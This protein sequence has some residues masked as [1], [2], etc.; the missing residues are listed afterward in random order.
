MEDLFER[1][2]RILDHADSYLEQARKTGE[3]AVEEYASVVKA[4]RLLLKYMRRIT[5]LSDR[6]TVDLNTSKLDLQDKIHFDEL[7]GIYNRRFLEEGLGK[8]AE[9]LARSRKPLGVLMVD[10]DYFKRYNDTYGHGMGDDC[11]HMVAEAL[12]E[13]VQRPGDFAARYG[14]EEFVVVMPGADEEETRGMARR[15]L[16]SVR[17]RRIPHTGN[18]VAEWVTVSVGAVSGLVTE[19][20]VA[21]DFL[22]GADKALY[23]AKHNGRNQYIY[24]DMEEAQT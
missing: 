10:V 12:K 2:Q 21:G 18:T 4:Y 19:N 15:L 3:C 20:R 6:T 7:T 11:L 16:E 22:S 1:E 17:L 24:A 8:A 13:S 23:R 14:G 9:E 5:K